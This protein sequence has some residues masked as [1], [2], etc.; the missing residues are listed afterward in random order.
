MRRLAAIFTALAVIVVILAV[1]LWFSNV[2]ESQR[3]APSAAPGRPVPTV[4]DQ[5]A[6]PPM[7]VVS[8]VA[9]A[10]ERKPLEKGRGAI[11]GR[12]YTM[13]AAPASGAA[14]TAQWTG[15]WESTAMAEE[16]PGPVSV[17]ADDRGF[18]E[19]HELP[20]GRYIVQARL[21]NS[22]AVE[23]AMLYP[24]LVGNRIKLILKS[25][26]S[27]IGGEIVDSED[28][29]VSN[30]E[31]TPVL[32]DGEEVS[33]NR[34]LSYLAH[35]DSD[36]HFLVAAL[37]PKMWAFYVVADDYAPLC[38]EPI[39][40]GTSDARLILTQGGAIVGTVVHAET[41][42]PMP[43]FELLARLEGFTV[44]PCVT[45]TDETGRFAFER[46]A[47]RPHTVTPKNKR[48]IVAEGPGTIPVAEGQTVRDVILKVTEGGVVRGRVFDADSGKGL[49]ESKVDARAM[50]PNAP[51]DWMVSPL[52]DADGRYELSGLAKANYAVTVNPPAG[53]QNAVG[54]ESRRTLA[55]TP[56]KLIEGVDFPL[57]RGIVITGIVVDAQERPV[58]Y[59]EVAAVAVPPATQ[60]DNGSADEAGG[61]ELAGF[62]PEQ[63][64]TMYASSPDLRSR[65]QGPFTIPADG[66]RDLRI[67]LELEADAALSGVVVDH[68]GY[69]KP[70]VVL[71]M[72]EDKSLLLAEARMSARTDA[73][74]RFV[75]TGLVP[76]TY[77]VQLGPYGHYVHGI[78][79]AT[80]LTLR[81]HEVRS[82]LRLVFDDSHI[83][84]ISGRVTDTEGK[85]IELAEVF[86]SGEDGSGRH[87]STD[88]NGRYTIDNVA[89]IE[90]DVSA[91]HDR[92]GSAILRDVRAGTE[93]ADFV[94]QARPRMEGQV[95]DA[96]T[97]RPVPEYEI[98]IGPAYGRAV[99]MQKVAN[100]EGRFSLE[101][102]P[103][104]WT[105]LVRASNYRPTETPEQ[106]IEPGQTLRDV[107]IPLEAGQSRVEGLVRRADGSPV[108]GARIIL[109]N[110]PPAALT[111]VPGGAQ[112]MATDVAAHTDD[113]GRFVVE[114]LPP[115]C[116]RLFV[117]SPGYATG[118]AEFDPQAQSVQ[119]VEIVLVVGGSLEGT[120]TDAGKPVEHTAVS[121]RTQDG[122]RGLAFTDADGRY[123]IENL[124]P[125][126]VTV[127][128][129]LRP[130]D[131]DSEEPPPMMEQPA[132]ITSDN[133]IT[134]D[135]PFSPK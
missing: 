57:H 61:F 39:E 7:P 1:W 33:P 135:F 121:V 45:M 120:V 67:V 18:F 36:G 111:A 35:S 44:N 130:P 5:P 53:Y 79:T 22:T 129:R 104:R 60:R 25:R 73:E 124:T 93:N 119:Q 134:L 76:A 21:G 88:R 56:G 16:L 48:L 14:I 96:K 75:M 10:V 9:E 133:V 17:N 8:P 46:L 32:H 116:T 103:G 64:V 55:V 28:R 102:Q 123:L 83:L 106:P 29:P 82:G 108:P 90:R 113:A 31:I 105:L 84:R 117:V 20:W 110:L 71:A 41:G 43:K 34:R 100:P 59:A 85:P 2:P 69:P 66:L 115:E 132:T 27:G 37:G 87:A 98:G 23:S 128:V 122:V 77:D 13:E 19:F 50:D 49:A 54:P 74:G 94:L 97:G 42:E 72:P 81:S 40:A 80:T 58:P 125:G 91:R 63:Q 86:A 101:T 107:V 11:F 89:E 3:A 15:A 47:V 24:R 65:L 12:A 99:T 62:V 52:T 4:K 70:A 95:V 78:L 51:P 6:V 118:S 112:P 68:R 30:A 131:P 127:R 26:V 38:G 126:D 92:Y 109:G 114:S